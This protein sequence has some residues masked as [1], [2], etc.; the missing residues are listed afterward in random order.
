MLIIKILIA[1]CTSYCF[2]RDSN[3][4]DNKSIHLGTLGL[5]MIAFIEMYQTIKELG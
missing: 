1:A 4:K 5:F 3:D 2:Y